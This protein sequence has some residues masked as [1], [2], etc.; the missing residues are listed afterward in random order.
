M[1]IFQPEFWGE[2]LDVNFGRWISWGWIFE[3]GS[4]IGKHRAKKFD[5]R[6]RPQNSGLKNLHPR[7]RPQIRV[8]EVQNPLC[9][10]L[11]L[12]RLWWFWKIESRIFRSRKLL[13]LLRF[14]NLPEMKRARPRLGESWWVSSSATRA[15]LNGTNLR[16]QTPI[17]GFLPVPAVSCGFFPEVLWPV[18]GLLELPSKKLSDM[19][20]KLTVCCKTPMGSAYIT[21][22]T[23]K[24]EKCK[25]NP[26]LITLI[27]VSLPFGSALPFAFSRNSLR[28]WAFFPF[29]PKDF[30]GS[31][32]IRNPRFFDGFPCRFP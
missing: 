12:I 6:I 23:Q 24:C 10:N 19:V 25:R 1:W 9:G 15:A 2:F 5:P 30:G 29:F 18:C 20:A 21:L 3:G 26:N 27:F 17:C 14:G 28:F 7:M 32:S 4:F 22:S 8:H 16:G 31:A 13:H 11:P